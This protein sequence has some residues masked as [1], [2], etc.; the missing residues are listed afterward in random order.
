MA[1]GLLLVDAALL[2]CLCALLELEGGP[3]TP[4]VSRWFL[5]L[6]TAGPSL[7]MMRW[8][9]AGRR[10]AVCAWLCCQGDCSQSWLVGSVREGFELDHHQVP[11]S[12]GVIEVVMFAGY[13][14]GNGM[15]Y[16]VYGLTAVM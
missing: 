5:F 8:A 1:P 3:G 14:R 11:P 15:E 6:P 7:M 13:V 4:G 16:D 2:L 9:V 12:P 10:A